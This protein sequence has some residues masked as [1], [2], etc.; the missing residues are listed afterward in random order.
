[1]ES[2]VSDGES[3]YCVRDSGSTQNNKHRILNNEPHSPL[4]AAR[5]GQTC[6]N[7]HSQVSSHWF[8]CSSFTQPSPLSPPKKIT[9]LVCNMRPL[10][11][12][13]VEEYI[14]GN[15]TGR[16]DKKTY[17]VHILCI[18]GPVIVNL[19]W[20][21]GQKTCLFLRH[22]LYFKSFIEFSNKQRDKTEELKRQKK[23]R[24]NQTA[25]IK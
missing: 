15:G 1:M 22:N 12:W 4:P 21:F 9:P 11:S 20:G 14:K 23:S 2:D 5:K 6:A 18:R 13:Q 8:N 16:S 24:R 17:T 3:K 19:G 10:S 7:L 25:E